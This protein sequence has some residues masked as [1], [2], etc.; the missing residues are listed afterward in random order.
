MGVCGCR[1]KKEF[2]MICSDSILIWHMIVT[3]DDLEY[4]LE[5]RLVYFSLFHK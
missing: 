4:L 3:E 1:L 5:I 2:A